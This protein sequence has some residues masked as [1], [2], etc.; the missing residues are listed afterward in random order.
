MKNK[1]ATKLLLLLCVFLVSFV[2]TTRNYSVKN[3][4]II[5]SIKNAGITVNGTLTNLKTEILFDPQKPEDSKIT[6][7]ASAASINTENQM[8]DNHL[9]KEEYIDATAFPVVS[10][11][12]KS[13]KKT[14]TISYLG[15]F[16]L[17]IKNKI[18]EVSIPF[19]FLQ[20]P[21]KTAFVGNFIFNRRDFDIGGYSFTMS[22]EIKVK[23]DIEV[24]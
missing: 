17:K 9:R 5:F 15:L 13:I 16:D 12:S 3:A 6:A 21:E 14:G 20:L 2:P 22:D 10:L 23:L 11:K 1:L 24:E 18:K 19:N 8:R 4:S 7:T